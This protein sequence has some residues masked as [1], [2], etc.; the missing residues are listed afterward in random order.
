MKFEDVET[1]R[2]T[3]WKKLKTTLFISVSLL[4]LAFILAVI[5]HVFDKIVF[6]IVIFVA[7]IVNVV[8]NTKNR[9]IYHKTYKTYFVEQNLH[10]VFTDVIYDHTKGLNPSLLHATG[11]I[12]TGDAYSS[13]DLT[14]AKYKNIDFMQADATIKTESTDSDGHTTYTT[15][16]K[17]R[18][19]IFEFPKKFDFKL[20][21]IGKRFHAYRVPGKDKATGR[22]MVKIQTESTEFNQKFKIYG[23]DGFEAFYILDP[24]MIVRIQAISDYYKDK[25]FLG[26][27]DNK[28]LV[29]LDDRKDSFEPPK[30][31]RPINE[32]EEI[33][34]IAPSIKVITDFIDAIV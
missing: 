14:I 13:N 30:A 11:M 16:F 5:F 31:S 32:A 23:Q 21:I 24:A 4:I 1:A 19:M 7:I 17:G 15:I 12:D 22:K 20:E 25:V 3:Y 29:G 8:V 26:F 10:R 27:Y 2:K 33:Q 34:K 6:Y 28:M 18:F 9:Y